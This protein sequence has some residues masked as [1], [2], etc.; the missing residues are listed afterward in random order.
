MIAGSS[1]ASPRISWP[2]RAT[3]T[4]NG[5]RATTRTTEPTRCA[6]WALIR[7]CRIGSNIRSSHDERFVIESRWI[8]NL[9]VAEAD[10]I[11]LEHLRH[12]RRIVDETRED[13][14]EIKIRVGT[15]E[16]EVAQLN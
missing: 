13:V 12:I 4:S 5:S 16:R 10:N 15:L 11:V 8:R 6:G 14:R 1:T 7:S 2:S 3:V 9:P